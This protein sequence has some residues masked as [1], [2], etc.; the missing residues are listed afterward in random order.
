MLDTVLKELVQLGVLVDPRIIPEPVG[1]IVEQFRIGQ[2]QTPRV[3]SFRQDAFKQD[4]R[5]SLGNAA[6]LGRRSEQI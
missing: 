2:D 6:R 3:R 4:S 5:D 1:S